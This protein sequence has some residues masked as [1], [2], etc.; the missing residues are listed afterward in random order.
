VFRR[1][2][3]GSLQ[4]GSFYNLTERNNET[5]IDVL[6]DCFSVIDDVH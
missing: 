5:D 1:R 6:C 3:V 2:N 4:M